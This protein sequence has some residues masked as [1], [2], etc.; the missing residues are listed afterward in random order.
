MVQLFSNIRSV[1]DFPID[2]A[3]R[4]KQHQASVGRKHKQESE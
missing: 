4:R 2:D 3:K 1:L